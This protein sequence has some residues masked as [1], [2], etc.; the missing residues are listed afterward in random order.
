M[1]TASILQLIMPFLTQSLVDTGIRDSNLSF[2]TL[3]LIAQLVILLPGCLLI[4][5]A[6]GFYYMSIP[7]SISL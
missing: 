7:E 5:S 1:L 3:I 4:L 6:V 2:I